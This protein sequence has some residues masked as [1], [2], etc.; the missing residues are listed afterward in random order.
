MDDENNLNNSDELPIL[1]EDLLDSELT[2]D[3]LDELYDDDD[4]DEASYEADYDN[5]DE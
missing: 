2:E 4:E 1:D 3:E 5:Y